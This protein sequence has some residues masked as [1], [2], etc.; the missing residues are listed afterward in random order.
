MSATYAET[1]VTLPVTADDGEEELTIPA[2]K[3]QAIRGNAKRTTLTYRDGETVA[4]VTVPLGAA[5]VWAL[6]KPRMVDF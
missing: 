4:R 2:T 3:V 6:V 1:F 5:E